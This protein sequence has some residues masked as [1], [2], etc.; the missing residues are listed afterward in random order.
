M[1]RRPPDFRALSCS[2]CIGGADLDFDFTMAFQPIVDII[3]MEV[4]AQEALVRG[5]DPAVGGGGVQAGQ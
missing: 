1:T 3:R 2:E 4:Y 5:P